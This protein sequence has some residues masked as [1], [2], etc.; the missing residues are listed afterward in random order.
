MGSPFSSQIYLLGILT[1]D[2]LWTPDPDQPGELYLTE[3]SENHPDP[4]PSNWTTGDLLLNHPAKRIIK[5]EAN[6]VPGRRHI[7]LH[8]LPAAAG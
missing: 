7:P 6:S 3:L 4:I 1:C 2:L 8:A 5:D